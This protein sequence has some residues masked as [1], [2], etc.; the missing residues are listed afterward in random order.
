MIL[1]NGKDAGQ[2]MDAVQWHST[3]GKAVCAC[4][5]VRRGS[6]PPAGPSGPAQE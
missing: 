1:M 4:S 5:S 6:E 2:Q 3:L